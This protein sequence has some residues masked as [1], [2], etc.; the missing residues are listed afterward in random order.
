MDLYCNHEK[1]LLAGDFNVQIGKSSIDDFLE[2]FGAK[3][4]VKDFTCFKSANNPSCVDLFITSSW[5]SFKST[6]P[7][8]TRLSDFHK[9]IVTVLKTT[10]PKNKPK[11]IVYRDFS[12]FVKEHFREALRAELQKTKV[13]SYEPFENLYLM[14]LNI[15]APVK[16]K[17]IRANHKPYI[18]KH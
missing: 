9:M 12:K 6:T 13:I 15:H 18:S 3:N 17:I 16:K 4:L 5:N 1:F 14:V 11:V 7:V 10:F 2:A 8:S